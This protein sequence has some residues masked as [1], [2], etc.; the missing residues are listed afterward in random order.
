MH[1]RDLKCLLPGE[2]SF[3]VCDTDPKIVNVPKRYIYN[4]KPEF[5][6]ELYLS[7]VF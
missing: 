6:Y 2:I 1:E 7:P 4:L 3:S 5:I